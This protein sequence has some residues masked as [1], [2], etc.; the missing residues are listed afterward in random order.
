[1]RTRV[2]GALLVALF[3]GVAGAAAQEPEVSGS[4]PAGAAVGEVRIAPPVGQGLVIG[5]G[6]G[7]PFEMP[8][9]VLAVEPFETGKP[10][11][12]APYSAEITTE[13]VQRLADGNRIERRSTSS[14]ARDAQGRVRREQQVTAIGPILP[15]GDA[16]IVTISDPVAKVHYSLDA[17]RKVAIQ[18]PLRFEAT[19]KARPRPSLEARNDKGE[20]MPPHPAAARQAPDA[21][22]EAL[23]TREIEGVTAEGTRMTATIPAGAIGNQAPIEIVSERWYSPELQTVV[24]SNRSDPRFGD[25]TYAVRN[26]VRM[27][28]PAELFQ[29]PPDYTVEQ[30]KGLRINKVLRPPGQ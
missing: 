10:V 30:A 2:L 22:T 5:A 15:P 28:P 7:D 11:T 4:P 24:L 8:L 13:I 27:E 1:M 20:L 29:V 21:R 19:F 17:E 16:R 25:T 26:I 9:D 3:S 12:G 14:V 18:L 23:G 6:A